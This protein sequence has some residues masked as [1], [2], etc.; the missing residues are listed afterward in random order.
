[1]SIILYF[2][3]FQGAKK[4][5]QSE[6]SRRDEDLKLSQ[7]MRELY[8]IKTEND[9]PKRIANSNGQAWVSRKSNS[10]EEDKYMNAGKRRSSQELEF[11]DRTS[12]KRDVLGPMRK[13]SCSAVPAIHIVSSNSNNSNNLCFFNNNS[14]FCKFQST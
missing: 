10:S 14:K 9:L 4:R 7:R 11:N 13:D 2:S 1:M 12:E 3:T 6:S 5:S 8:D